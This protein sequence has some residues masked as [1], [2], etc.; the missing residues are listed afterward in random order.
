M[1]AAITKTDTATQLSLE[2]T[3]MAHERTLM[4]WVRTAASQIS[5]G[6][7]IYKFFQL[8]N[9]HEAARK[10]LLTPRDFALMLVS[11][12]LLSL[13]IATFQHRKDI[14]RI[15][16]QMEVRQFSLAEL[17]SWLISIFGVLVLLAAIIR[18]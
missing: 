10:G 14:R 17:I 11:V 6:F 1:D 9:G 12:G 4:A 8:D 13:V 3:W 16:P 7:T 2:R 18:R 5:F 15:A